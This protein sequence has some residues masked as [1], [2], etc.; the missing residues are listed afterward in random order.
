MRKT[1]VDEMQIGTVFR[2]G[3]IFL[4]AT[5]SFSGTVAVESAQVSSL[6][7]W[8]LPDGQTIMRRFIGF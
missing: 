1:F 7:D 3:D 8:S 6:R 5:V 4:L 2:T